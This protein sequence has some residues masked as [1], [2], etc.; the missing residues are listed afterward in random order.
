MADEG[1]TGLLDEAKLSEDHWTN[2]YDLDDG[3]IKVLGRYESLEEALKGHV[4]LEQLRGRS[5]SL[6]KDDDSPEEKTKQY[7]SIYTKLGRPAK[8]E[9]YK[10]EKPADLPEG[11]GWDE[12][13]VKQFKD[14]A[15]QA[16]WNQE[17]MDVAVGFYNNWQ[18]KLFKA[19]QETQTQLKAQ[20]E[21]AQ[22]EAVIKAGN[23][24]KTEWGASF[25]KNMA[26]VVKAFEVYGT[27]ALRELF[28]TKGIDNDPVV[29]KAF[30]EVY[31]EKI[32]EDRHDRH[33]RGDER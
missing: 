33:C 4:N 13:A 10:I 20:E 27:A 24:L 30:Y 31:K 29:L 17:Q 18:T 1:T 5:I 28:K 7:D 8:A 6:P 19:N 14:V 15:H 21:A 16:R 25:E 11:M 32:A 23:A 26:G 9:D 12:E 22:K 2:D 3:A